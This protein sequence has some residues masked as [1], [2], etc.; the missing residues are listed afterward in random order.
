MDN[1]EWERFMPKPGDSGSWP[2]TRMEAIA[3]DA[4]LCKTSPIGARLI[5]ALHDDDDHDDEAEEFMVQDSDDRARLGRLE[6]G[7]ATAQEQI[8]TATRH[9]HRNANVLQVLLL[10]S[11]EQNAAIEAAK[12][13]HINDMALLNER[14][15]R[16]QERLEGPLLSLQRDRDEFKALANKIAIKWAFAAGVGGV[17]LTLILHKLGLGWLAP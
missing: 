13:K 12:E 15:T 10:G 9:N 7:L 2:A 4:L 1:D 16:L 11:G 3:S 5:E 17:L 8:K 6:V 14:L